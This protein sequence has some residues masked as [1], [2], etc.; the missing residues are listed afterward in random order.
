MLDLARHLLGPVVKHP[1][2]LQLQQ[3]DGDAVTLLEVV[4]HPADR[5]A[6]EA[7]DGRMLRNVRQVI[8]A[9]AGS[10]KATLELVEA[11]SSEE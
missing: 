1:D 6:L 7:E 2:A 3:V 11:F 5:E 4:V 10:R 8:S 9:A